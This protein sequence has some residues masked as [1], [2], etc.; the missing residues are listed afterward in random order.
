MKT[1]IWKKSLLRSFGRVQQAV[2]RNIG[3]I[4]GL[5][6]LNYFTILWTNIHMYRMDQLAVVLIDGVFLLVGT[7][8]YV[9]LLD[10]VPV[11]ALRRFLF[12]ASF[13]ISGVL[14]GLE[15]FSICNYQALVGAG[16]VTAVLQTNPAEAGEF[17]GR[18]VG[19]KGAL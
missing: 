5:F 9:V 7:G 4:F 17:L 11:N 13:F 1:D 19:W 14:G 8:M 15:L 2:E 12:A 18:Y 3:M 6:F 10:L 16:I